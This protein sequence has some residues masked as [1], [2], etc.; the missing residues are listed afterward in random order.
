[1]ENKKAIIFTTRNPFP[2]NGGDKVRL[3]NH[4]QYY[5]KNNFDVDLVII[6]FEKKNNQK[7]FYNFNK[8]INIKPSLIIFLKNIITKKELPLQ[9]SLYFQE[10]IRKK[11][12][13]KFKNYLMKQLLIII[14]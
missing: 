4:L 12:R 3:L 2:A 14:T 7:L 9:L 6:G 11:I 5:K 10:S 13:K 1:M 8:V